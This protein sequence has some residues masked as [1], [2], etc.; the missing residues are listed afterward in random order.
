[1]AITSKIRIS[2]LVMILATNLHEFTRI[3]KTRSTSQ[4]FLQK[5]FKVF[6]NLAGRKPELKNKT[7]ILSFLVFFLIY[8]SLFIR[9]TVN[10]RSKSKKQW[11]FTTFMIPIIILGIMFFVLHKIFFE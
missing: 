2:N 6:E 11:T 9:G 5:Y 3:K 4:L 10:P 7:K 1:M 8:Y